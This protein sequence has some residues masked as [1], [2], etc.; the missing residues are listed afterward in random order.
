MLVE[1]LKIWK[2]VGYLKKNIYI[3]KLKLKEHILN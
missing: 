2:K 3:C 1:Q